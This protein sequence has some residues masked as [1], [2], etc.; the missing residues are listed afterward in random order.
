MPKWEAVV[1]SCFAIAGI[2]VL[3]AL[4]LARGIDGVAMSA[5]IAAIAAIAGYRVGRGRGAKQ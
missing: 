1:L 4:A 2:V 3:E 5:A